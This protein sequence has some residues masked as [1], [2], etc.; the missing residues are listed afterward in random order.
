MTK[1][2]LF[3]S[4]YWDKKLKIEMTEYDRKSILEEDRVGTAKKNSGK[5]KIKLDI[6]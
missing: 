4:F 5:D 3:A 1:Q 2:K 6:L